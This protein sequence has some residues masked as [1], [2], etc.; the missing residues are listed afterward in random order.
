MQSIILSKDV[1]LGNS[2]LF[3]ANGFWAA[4]KRSLLNMT[5]SMS[6]YK[7]F[8]IIDFERKLD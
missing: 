4:N 3:W 5:Y 8:L 2:D 6:S 7:Y 1:D